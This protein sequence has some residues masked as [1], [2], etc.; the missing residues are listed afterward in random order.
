MSL[1]SYLGEYA[2]EKYHAILNRFTHRYNYIEDTESEVMLAFCEA[3]Q[4]YD[5]SR[6]TDFVNYL[7]SV[8]HAHFKRLVRKKYQR[9]Q[10]VRNLSVTPDNIYSFDE[11]KFEQLI[12]PG[13]A[14]QII[15][16]ISEGYSLTESA[17]RL[18][19]AQSTASV[20]VGRVR[21]K[22]KAGLAH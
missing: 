20:I 3:V 5:E 18:N 1:R 22:H 11:H 2:P 13:R 12:I 9:E 16:L 15:Q 19:I 21:R 8:L 6:S 14:G 10:A 4:S 17:K 7:F